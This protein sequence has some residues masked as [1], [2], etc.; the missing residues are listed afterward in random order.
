M[1]NGWLGHKPLKFL[2]DEARSLPLPK[3]NDLWLVYIGLLDN[4][5]RKRPV[6]KAGLH[7]QLLYVA[8]FFFAGY[9]YLKHQ[10]YLYAVKDH[11]MFGYIKLHPED[12]PEKE[13]KSYAE[14]LEAFHPVR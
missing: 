14:I 11:D 4:L 13:K 8:S 7:R 12:F 3:L 1:M 9:F 6:M 10:D 5:I 2:P